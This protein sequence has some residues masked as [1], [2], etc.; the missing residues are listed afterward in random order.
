MDVFHASTFMSQEKSIKK[1][2][3]SILSSNQENMC[4]LL[5]NFG[6]STMD[7]GDQFQNIIFNK[8][9]L[10]HKDRLDAIFV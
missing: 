9:H 7:F 4:L 3:P 10:K 5:P 6:A 2:V 8:E 1:M